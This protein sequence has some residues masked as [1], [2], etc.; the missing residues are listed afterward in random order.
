[1]E[2]YGKLELALWRIY[3]KINP[4]ICASLCSIIQLYTKVLVKILK[5]YGCCSNK[6]TY[7]WTSRREDEFSSFFRSSPSNILPYSPY[8]YMFLPYSPDF[9]MF[10]SRMCNLHHVHLGQGN[11]MQFEWHTCGILNLYTVQKSFI[12]TSKFVLTTLY[13]HPGLIIKL[14]NDNSKVMINCNLRIIII[15]WVLLA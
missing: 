1:M 6:F 9:Y 7:M 12:L 2:L 10:T 5:Y 4:F 11:K 15:F 13:T 3:F 8:F 14:H